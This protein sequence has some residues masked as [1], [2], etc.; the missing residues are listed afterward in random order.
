M[1]E[2]E[3][4]DGARKASFPVPFAPAAVLVVCALLLVVLGVLPFL[5]GTTNAFF[6]DAGAAMQAAGGAGP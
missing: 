3:A 6:P 4:E 1:D 5:L 2:S